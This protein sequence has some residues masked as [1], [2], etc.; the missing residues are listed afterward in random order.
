VLLAVAGRLEGGRDDPDQAEQRVGFLDEGSLPIAAAPVA[1]GLPASGRATVVLIL[2]P[3]DARYWE[4]LAGLG[5]SYSGVAPDLP[6]AS[7]DRPA[8]S[9]A[10][11]SAGA[12]PNRSRARRMTT[13]AAPARRSHQRLRGAVP[14]APRKLR[15]AEYA[16]PFSVPA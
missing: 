8:S 16:L 4:R 5:G 9:R 15:C 13:G 11:W 6:L 2:R 12:P 1:S 7:R 14:M 10:G 3:D